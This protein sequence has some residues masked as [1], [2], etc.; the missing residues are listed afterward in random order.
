MDRDPVVDQILADYSHLEPGQ[1]DSWNPISSKFQLGYRLNLFYALA[2]ALQYVDRPLQDL[3]V[4][5][6]GCGNGRSTRMYVDMG[7]QPQQLR[8]LDLRPGA[9]ELASKLNPAISWD[10]HDGGKL[11]TGHN[12]LSASTVFSSVTGRENRE[13]IAARIRDSLPAG[14]HVFYYDLRKANPFAGGDLIDPKR[15]FAGFSLVWGER[16]GRFT[17]VPF[18]DRLRGLLDSGFQGDDRTPSLRE[19]VSDAVAPSNE[20]LLLRKT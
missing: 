15:L 3:R 13:S 5:D 12:W 6:L 19:M 16:L 18:R 9:I 20:V 10:I 7:L 17:G 14:G 4:L 2:K 1:S 11:P 8:G